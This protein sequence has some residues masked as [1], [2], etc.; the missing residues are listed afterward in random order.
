MDMFIDP[1]EM[2]VQE[3]LDLLARSPYH[4]SF[5][6]LASPINLPMTKKMQAPESQTQHGG[7]YAYQP[8]R[9]NG[10][11]RLLELLPGKGDMPLQGAIYH[12]SLENPG[13]F[14]ALSYVWGAATKLFTLSTPGGNIY[15]TLS[16]DSALRCVRDAESP[17][18]IWVDA[19]CIDQDTHLEKCIQIWLLRK[20]FQAAEE[21]VA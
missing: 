5:K 20:I 4:A 10:E 9:N 11:I 6:N 17:T 16:L 19:I 15:I 2:Y 13:E 3:K 7:T 1:W 8:L 14:L 18:R 21:V 12:V